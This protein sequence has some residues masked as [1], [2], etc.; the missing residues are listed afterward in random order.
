MES[1]D[2]EGMLFSR[3]RVRSVSDREGLR[4]R[5]REVRQA[6]PRAQNAQS[7]SPIAAETARAVSVVSIRVPTRCCCKLVFSL[8]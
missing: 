8:A 7:V 4:V 2:D 1:A 5:G 3:M 6:C